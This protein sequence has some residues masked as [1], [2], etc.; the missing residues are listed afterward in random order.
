MKCIFIAISLWLLLASPALADYQY[1][2]DAF[3]KGEYEVAYTRWRKAAMAG[4]KQ[5]QHHLAGLYQEGLGAPKSPKLAYIWYTL[6]AQS[7]GEEAIEA[8]KASNDMKRILTSVDL[9]EADLMLERKSV[10]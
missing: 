6:A 10:V 4:D 2:L 1:G 5:A 7:G 9:A 8:G 3:N